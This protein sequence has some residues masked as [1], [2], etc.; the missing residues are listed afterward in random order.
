MCSGAGVSCGKGDWKWSSNY[1]WAY[2]LAEEEVPRCH[3]GESSKG[4]G[5]DSE[6]VSLWCKCTHCVNGVE[7]LR[8]VVRL[9]SFLFLARTWLWL[10]HWFRSVSLTCAIGFRTVRVLKW[11][12]QSSVMNSRRT[13]I[14][15]RLSEYFLAS[16]FLFLMATAILVVGRSSRLF[17][18]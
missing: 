3:G 8:R 1:G 6:K 14:L 11:L 7:R 2:G 16:V 4:F 9:A 13:S 17:L 12:Q 5:R 10:K 15:R 18:E